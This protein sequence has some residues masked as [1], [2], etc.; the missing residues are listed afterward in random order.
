MAQGEL[1]RPRL[2]LRARLVSGPMREVALAHL[3]H[4]PL[5]NLLLIDLVEQVGGATSASEVAPQVL[6]A[7]E[8]E[9]GEGGEGGADG[10]FHDGDRRSPPRGAIR[11]VAALRPSLVLEAG[12]DAEALDVFLPYLQTIE[13]GLVKSSRAVVDRLW[14]SLELCGRRASIDRTEYAHV[15]RRGQ[16]Q[17]RPVTDPAHFRPA[18][19]PIWMRSFSR[20]ARAFVRRGGPTPSTATPPASA[21]GCADGCRT[22]A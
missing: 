9:G 4:D 22:R 8:S 16:G 15:L 3:L 20:P 19:K 1:H 12:L 10:A 2:R 5:R 6:G 7:F 11:G 21:A 14:A 17:L 13:S 18:A